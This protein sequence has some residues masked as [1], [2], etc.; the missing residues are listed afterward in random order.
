MDFWLIL[1]LLGALFTWAQLQ[2]TVTNIAETL[3]R[4]EQMLDH[5]EER[6]TDGRS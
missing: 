1:G 6:V 4:I 2:T 3:V 5:I